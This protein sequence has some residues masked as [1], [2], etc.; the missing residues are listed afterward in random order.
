MLEIFVFIA[1]L[2][3]P[4]G[5]ALSNQVHEAGVATSAIAPAVRTFGAS[6]T[7]VV[8]VRSLI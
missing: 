5:R 2:S 3:V 1:S 4:D 8:A 7:S 6:L